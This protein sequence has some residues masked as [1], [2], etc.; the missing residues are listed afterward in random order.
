MSSHACVLKLRWSRLLPMQ[1]LVFAVKERPEF[2]AQAKFAMP[3]IP[4]IRSCLR[5]RPW[6]VLMMS[7]T[8]LS[9]LNEIVAMFQYL[10]QYQ[11]KVWLEH[12]LACHAALRSYCRTSG[13][14]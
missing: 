7:G 12:T 9:L 2:R 5:N 14:H 10:V 4:G 6:V 11:F 8:T 1:L 13:Q 3:L